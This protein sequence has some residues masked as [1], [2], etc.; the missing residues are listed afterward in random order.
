MPQVENERRFRL[1]HQVLERELQSR[2]VFFAGSAAGAGVDAVEN[3]K[4][5]LNEGGSGL[6][7]VSTGSLRW[8]VRRA[9]RRAQ[10][11]FVLQRKIF[12]RRW[13]FIHI[14]FLIKNNHFSCNRVH[15]FGN[16]K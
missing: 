12:P 6:V 7:L 2:K 13:K 5:V 3:V 1:E 11:P 4:R 10:L 15:D 14:V 16:S 8:V 9:I